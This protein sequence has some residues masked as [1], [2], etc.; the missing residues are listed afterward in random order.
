MLEVLLEAGMLCAGTH[1]TIQNLD[2][3]LKFSVCFSTFKTEKL[4]NSEVVFLQVSD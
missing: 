1:C 3:F 4:T 2:L